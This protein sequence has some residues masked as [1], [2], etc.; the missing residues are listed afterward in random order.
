MNARRQPNILLIVL[1]TLRRDRL[2]TYGHTAE[3][4]PSLD[5]FAA[6]ATV[7]TRAIAPAQWTIPSHA[8]LFT[9]LYP[10]EHQLTQ[11]N[12]LLSG[13]YPTLAEILRGAGYETVAFCNNPLV[14]A[15]DHGLQRGFDHF[16]NYSTAVPNRP[17]DSRRPFVRREFSRRFRPTARKI[18]NT[19]ARN[20]T[21]FRL[22][23]HPLLTPVWSRGINFKGST[24]NSIGDL[25]DFMTER[26]AGG[27]DAPLFAFVNLMGAHLPYQPPSDYLQRVAPDLRNDKPAHAFM[28]RWNADAA[29]WASPTDPPLTDWQRHT[30]MGFYDAEI[31]RQDEHVGRLLTHLRAS[32]ALD[33][34]TVILTADHGEAHGDHDL[35]GHGFVVYQ[36]LV[37]VP[38]I[39]YGP[40]HFPRGGEVT[41]NVSTRRLFHTVLDLAGVEPPLDAADPNADV[42]GLSL[43]TAVEG[44]RAREHDLAFSEAVP[45]TTFLNVIEHRN[46]AAIHRLLLRQTRRGIYHG[47]HKLAVVGERVEGL[48]DVSRDQADAHD[49]AAE[50]PALT[51]ALQAK[52]GAFVAATSAQ[53]SGAPEST[54][55]SPAV[56]EQLRA[57]GYIE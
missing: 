48:Y 2:S 55:F 27:Q 38:L 26:R 14:G 54:T 12:G 4:S 8:S 52:L 39:V 18:G 45:P 41:A 47:A 51:Q 44:G 40:E 32:G 43:V 16:Y 42:A 57:L 6:D 11:G 36:E 5:R 24:E 31:A 34:T 50:Q 46:P 1:D 28:R 22:S 9:G 56:E 37:H 33:H 7:F 53:K 15:L 30:L 29:A 21:L 25:I 19:F 13:A 17:F 23:L 20:D 35:F 49:V 3:T 10:S